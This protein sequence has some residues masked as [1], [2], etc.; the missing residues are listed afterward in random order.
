MCQ[1]TG[2]LFLENEDV[3]YPHIFNLLFLSN[4]QAMLKAARQLLFLYMKLK[5]NIGKVK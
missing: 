4:L 3:F 2:Q 5:T 1:V